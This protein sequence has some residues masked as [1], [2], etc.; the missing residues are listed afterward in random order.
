MKLALGF[1]YCFVNE[2]SKIE[3]AISWLESYLVSYSVILINRRSIPMIYEMFLMSLALYKVAA[4]RKEKPGMNTL[5]LIRIIVRDQ[6]I[7]FLACVCSIK[8]CS[9]VSSDFPAY[10]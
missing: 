3:T 4:I 7:Y 9:I 1:T 8:N 10:A 6:T 2:L 5:E